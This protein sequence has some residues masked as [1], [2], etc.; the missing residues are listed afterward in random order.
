MRHLITL[1]LLTACTQLSFA[2]IR[3][4][5]YYFKKNSAELTTD[6]HQRLKEFISTLDD[7]GIQIL[8]LSSFA[9]GS[10]PDSNK[11]L[12][13]V[14]IT[15]VIDVLGLRNKPVTINS[16][17]SKRINVK[18]TPLNWNRID[19]YCSS[20]E[21]IAYPENEEDESPKHN[22][23]SDPDI[24]AHQPLVLNILFEGGTSVMIQETVSSL[25]T[26]CDTLHKNPKLMAH[27]RGHVCCDNN[28]RLSKLRAKEIHD[29]LVEK[30]ISKDRL[31]Y[32]GYSNRQPLVHPERNAADRRVNRRVDVIFSMEETD[33]E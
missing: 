27:I 19:I 7:T 31:S 10:T 29:F 33:V 5:S 11:R 20:E 8:E 22:E 15:Y 3:V 30:G 9:E 1:I 23:V 28:M 4:Q 26:L 32:K 17:G 24:N 14:R 25:H 13:D 18:F 2:A 12:S 6:S 16:W 21:F